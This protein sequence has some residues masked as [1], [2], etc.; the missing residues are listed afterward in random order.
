MVD[1]P[2]TLPDNHTHNAQPCGLGNKIFQLTQHCFE[3]RTIWELDRLPGKLIQPFA[4]LSVVEPAISPAATVLQAAD[5]MKV[6]ELNDPVLGFAQF[7]YS[8]NLVG[9]RGSDPFVNASGD[10]LDRLSPAS[11]ILSARQ[12]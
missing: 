8:G 2:E 11:H 6:T 12:E 9:D 10:R 7:E 4:Q 1:S 5:Q 3:L